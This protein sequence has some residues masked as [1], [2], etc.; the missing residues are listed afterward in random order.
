M[1][2]ETKNNNTQNNVVHCSLK[3]SPGSMFDDWYPAR[4]SLHGT[5][6]CPD[7]DCSGYNRSCSTCINHSGR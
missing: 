7:K 4:C 2:T 5:T 6:V 1:K 3:N